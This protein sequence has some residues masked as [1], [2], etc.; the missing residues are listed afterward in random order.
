MFEVVEV[1]P[2]E[3]EPSRVRVKQ[4]TAGFRPRAKCGLPCAGTSRAGR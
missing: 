3:V 1:I 2:E 4:I